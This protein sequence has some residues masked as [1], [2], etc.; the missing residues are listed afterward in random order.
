MPALRFTGRD[1][2]RTRFLGRTVDAA[3]V[4]LALDAYRD[5]GRGGPML[6]QWSRQVRL[7]SRKVASLAAPTR[8]LPELW[9]M[10]VHPARSPGTEAEQFRH[11]LREFSA[12]ALDPFR[13][14]IAER[15]RTDRTERARVLLAGGVEELLAGLHP[16]IRWQSPA[17]AGTE[18]ASFLEVPCGDDRI[19]DLGGRGLRLAPS[20]FLRDRPGLLITTGTDA[21]ILLY[22]ALTGQPTDEL[23]QCEDPHPQALGALVGRTRAG[24]LRALRASRTTTELGRALGVSSAT[25]S[26][27]AAVLRGA[28]LISTRRRRNAVIHSLTPLGAALLEVAGDLE[29]PP[30]PPLLA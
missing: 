10:I 23:W 29:K 4:L 5:P 21:P 16:A 14:S 9:R 13:R 18:E 12:V 6:S 24:V 3:E 26:Q 15:V 7:R 2:A 28:G 27:H 22:P 25:A 30:I 11:V 1:I 20:L 17:P 8:P 19:V